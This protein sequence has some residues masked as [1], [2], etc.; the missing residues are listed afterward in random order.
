MEEWNLG[1]QKENLESKIFMT[2]IFSHKNI[3][4]KN[5]SKKICPKKYFCQKKNSPEILPHAKP[6]GSHASQAE[7]KVGAKVPCCPQGLG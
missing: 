7:T 5:M 4:E 2:K 3:S 6:P 1:D